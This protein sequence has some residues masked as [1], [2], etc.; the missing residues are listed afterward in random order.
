MKEST[1]DKHLVNQEEY[2][3]G[4]KDGLLRA[5]RIV[6]DKEQ[7]STGSGIDAIIIQEINNLV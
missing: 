3:Q 7:T 2:K 6:R 5:V 1:A 4:Y